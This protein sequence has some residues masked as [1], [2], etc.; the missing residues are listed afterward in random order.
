MNLRGVS[1]VV[2]IFRHFTQFFY[3]GYALFE[4]VEA[5]EIGSLK[6]QVSPALQELWNASDFA[7]GAGISG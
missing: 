4:I 2:H 7:S 6:D 5:E 1:A 3:S